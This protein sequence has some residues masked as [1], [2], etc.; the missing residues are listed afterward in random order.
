[1]MQTTIPIEVQNAD[2]LF[3][4]HSGGKDSQA[5]L[6]LLKR[7]GMLDRKHVIIVHADLGEMEWE[8]MHS[9]IEA[10]SFGMKVHVVKAP[11]DF[12]ELC[13]QTKR[14]PSGNMQYC[15]DVL[16][17]EPIKEYL[18]EYLYA[19]G[20]K[21]AVNVTGMRAAESKRREGKSPFTLSRGKHTSG[22]DMPVK[23]A[24]HTV[25]DWLPI[26][27]YS[28]VEVF[29][30]IAAAGQEPHEVYS[31]GFSRLSCVF[32]VNGKVEEH[33]RAA[34]LRPELAL[35]IANLERE[36]GKTYR[37]KQVNKVK[38]P[39]YL[40]EYLTA[41]PPKFTGAFTC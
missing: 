31:M 27:E 3:I 32:C 25:Y 17:I 28:T 37:L 29:A 19:H 39:K 24:E 5:T 8:P 35:K 38:L 15:T 10:N 12:F 36:L 34:E 33:Q 18:H 26:F 16:K 2:A 20:L 4:S 22:M 40:D 9:W 7:L 21:T 11:V 23:Y 41:L 14:L 6:A 13:R 30:E 1:M